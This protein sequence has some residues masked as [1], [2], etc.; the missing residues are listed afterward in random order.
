MRQN[1]NVPEFSLTGLSCASP[2]SC[3]VTEDI[4]NTQ[5]GAV[6]FAAQSWNGLSWQASDLAG[7]I[8]RLSG[9][10]CATTTDCLA[11]G[12][13]GNLA[14]AQLWNGTTWKLIT[15]VSP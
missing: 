12:R 13:S 9:V 15:P 3:V 1:A 11:V 5:S 2:T 14:M 4:E 7:T 6:S 8:S 10:S